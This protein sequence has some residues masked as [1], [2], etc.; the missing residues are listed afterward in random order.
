MR[1][2][3]LF[4]FILLPL[5]VFSQQK[6]ASLNKILHV[7]QQH[8]PTI[9]QIG[10]SVNTRQ[11]QLQ[12]SKLRKL[13]DLDIL[14][15]YTYQSDPIKINLQSVREGIINGTAQQNVDAANRIY[16]KITGNNLS[17]SAQDA[18]YG[19]AK[20]IINGIYPNFNPA[21]SEQQYFTA[22]LA[23]RIPIF[24]GGK[25]NA[26]QNLAQQ[27]VASGKI[28][29]ALTKNLI[30]V[31]V[32]SQ[33]MKI[34]YL[35]AMLTEQKILLS[36]YKKTKDYAQSMV[37]AEILPPYQAH[38]ANVALTQAKVGYQKF[39]LEKENAILSLNGLL[40]TDSSA[41]FQINQSISLA[42]SPI[43]LE[44][45][46]FWEKNPS[47][48]WLKSKTDLAQLTKK[49]TKSA[50][51]PNIFGI[52]NYQFL[53]KD[54]PLITPPWMIGIGLQWNIFSSFENAK[55]VKAAQSFVK[56][57]QLIAREKKKTLQRGLKTAQN[58]L[59]S[60][61]A[62]VKSL[63][64]ARKEATHTTEMIRK[65]MKNELSSVKDVNDALKVQLEA[66]KAYYS[67]ILA[68]NLAVTLYLNMLGTPESIVKYLK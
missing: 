55:K 46:S 43:Q 21:L 48:Q 39:Q 26:A 37:K 40:G 1:I 64:K 7:A 4:L 57:S 12:A 58:K 11:L 67:G 16:H 34:R 23:L 27:R 31:Q 35:N 30:T 50:S 45:Q 19:G 15:G 59:S 44:H 28:N 49:V 8:N 20:D 13:P 51:Y 3:I 17:Q 29:L 66:E 5:S 65:R 33:Y 41:D 52:A 68:Y 53:R 24:L 56:E 9:Q 42:S 60:L 25:L 2:L 62:Q 14:G 38:W 32:I 6:T 22:G 63:D 61:R 54:L 47:Y 36:L 18:I 10:Q